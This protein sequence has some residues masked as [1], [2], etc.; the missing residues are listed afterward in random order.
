[1]GPIINTMEEINPSVQDIVD[2]LG[3]WAPDDLALSWDNPGHTIGNPAIQVKTITCALDPSFESIEFA[4]ATG[5]ELLITH[6]PLPL[7]PLKAIRSDSVTGK[8]IQTLIHA[9]IALVSMHTNLDAAKGGV[10]DTLCRLLNCQNVS[11]ITDTEGVGLLRLGELVSHIEF[12]AL[13]S[14]VKEKLGARTILFTG[15]QEKIVKKVAVCGGAGGGYWG[16]AMAHGADCLITGE[17]RY[18]DALDARD[19]GF[20]I[21]AAGHFETERPVIKTLVRYLLKTAEDKGWGIEVVCFD[22][23]SSPL[24]IHNQ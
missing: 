3:K 5:A 8:R 6:H 21:G 15:N 20:N 12:S 10:N 19:W 18:H 11:T 4:R 16:L 14:M 17:V 24:Y 7:N 1:M 2:A 9:D 22:H 23:E 13:M